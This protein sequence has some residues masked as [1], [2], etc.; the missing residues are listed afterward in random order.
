[1][2]TF[3]Y[4]V[5]YRPDSD[6]LWDTIDYDL[7]LSQAKKLVATEKKRDKT[8]SRPFQYRILKVTKEVVK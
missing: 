2:K 1:M 7:N 5:Q 3:S 6:C 4:E 8:S